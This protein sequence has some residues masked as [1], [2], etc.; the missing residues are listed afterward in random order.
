LIF[1]LRSSFITLSESVAPW[2]IASEYLF[3]RLKTDRVNIDERTAAM[4]K[5]RSSPDGL[6]DG[7][8]RIW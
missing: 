4:R 8:N 3:N 1:V 6:A 5:Y 7:L 2:G